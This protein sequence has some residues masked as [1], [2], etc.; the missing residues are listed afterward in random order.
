MRQ[1]WTEV[2]PGVEIW[3][4]QVEVTEEEM[5]R[6]SLNEDHVPGKFRLVQVLQLVANEISLGSES[7]STTRA[8]ESIEIEPKIEQTGELA[9]VEDGC[10]TASSSTAIGTPA[11]GSSSP[12]IFSQ[13][14]EFVD[15]N[16]LPYDHEGTSVTQDAPEFGGDSDNESTRTD[17]LPHR[18]SSPSVRRDRHRT[19]QQTNHDRVIRRLEFGIARVTKR[20][21]HKASA[22]EYSPP[23]SKFNLY[24]RLTYLLC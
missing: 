23:H 9:D 11:S 18:E 5:S 4:P 10:S 1:G 24:S 20:K 8:A 7:S 13:L 16:E 19:I 17:F 22:L 3:Q 12:H 14:R 6:L 15:N 21:T 2:Q